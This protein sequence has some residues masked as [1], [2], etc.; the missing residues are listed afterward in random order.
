[1]RATKWVRG[2]F[3]NDWDQFGVHKH[4]VDRHDNRGDRI[5]GQCGHTITL[6]TVCTPTA[7]WGHPLSEGSLL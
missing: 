5:S 2:R 7:P 3:A 1:M 6:N 4:Q